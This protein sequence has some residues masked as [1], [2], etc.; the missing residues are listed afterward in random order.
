[1]L[2]DIYK[3]SLTPNKEET[4]IRHKVCPKKRN[5]SSWISPISKFYYF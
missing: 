5:Y 3:N 2:F 1:M 4:F